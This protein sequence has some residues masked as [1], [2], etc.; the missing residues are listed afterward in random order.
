MEI[1]IKD[2]PSKRTIR[3]S[4]LSVSDL[5]EYGAYLYI[6][7]ESFYEEYDD[8][9][10]IGNAIK[11]ET[12]QLCYIEDTESVAKYVGAPLEMEDKFEEWM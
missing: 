8:E 7:T 5:F 12:G 1:K 3:F 9:D 6:K 2:K 11:I 4:D 10:S